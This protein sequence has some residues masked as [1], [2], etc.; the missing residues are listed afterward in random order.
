MAG[1]LS[2]LECDK[3]INRVPS[4]LS[5]TS[6]FS[7]SNTSSE[8]FSNHTQSAVMTHPLQ[9]MSD[10]SSNGQCA[11]LPT[12]IMTSE[13]S[14]SDNISEQ[15]K[16]MDSMASIPI[17]SEEENRRCINEFLNK[18]DHTI[19]ESRKYVERSREYVTYF[20]LLFIIYQQ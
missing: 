6:I 15:S 2:K 1:I 3:P 13:H 18:I 12:L 9:L 7:S 10:F 5:T 16:S 11:V 8:S 14:N 17:S 4:S 20:C 19:S